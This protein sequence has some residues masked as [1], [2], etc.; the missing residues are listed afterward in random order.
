MNRTHTLGL[1]ALLVAAMSTANA[2]PVIVSSVGGAPT[3]ANRWNLDSPLTLPAG[4]TYS[5]TPDA[6]FVTG[7]SSGVYAAP[8]LSG[9]NGVGFGSGGG[10]QA[11]GVDTTQYVTTGSTGAHAGAQ[12]TI[13]FTSSQQ[14]FGLLW[15]SVDTYNTLSFYNGAT[16][17]GT[18]TGSQVTPSATGDQGA[19]GTYYVNINA[20]PF[21]SVRF[22]SSQ[23]AFEFDNIAWGSKPIGTP[24][25]GSLALLGLGL[26]G[27][28]MTRRRKA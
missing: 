26:F 14:Y 8:Y 11:N 12:F 19:N 15:G 7:S 27:L 28:G 20:D 4:V 13:S 1:A 18:I 25:P 3:G 21:T 22:T 23:Y 16:L 9:N 10:N 5:F 6:A 24:E 2:V 17:V